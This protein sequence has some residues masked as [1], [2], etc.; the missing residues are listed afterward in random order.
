[1][2]EPWQCGARMFLRR[3]DVSVREPNRSPLVPVI[4]CSPSSA[5]TA[6]MSWCCSYASPAGQA[7]GIGPARRRSG[8]PPGMAAPTRGRPAP[9]PVSQP[10]ALYHLAKKMFAI[11]IRLQ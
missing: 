1:M 10:C 8:Q 4:S 6:L 5:M 11:A 9:S 3:V 7:A 2:I